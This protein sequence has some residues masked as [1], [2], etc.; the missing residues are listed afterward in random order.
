MSTVFSAPKIPTPA[1][2]PPVPSPINPVIQ[3]AADDARI[4][5]SQAA[6][7]ASTILTSGQG[8][9]APPSAQK[10]TLLGG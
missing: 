2:P 10:K 6:G 4:A 1:P 8:V 9:T 7:R 5:A 3:G